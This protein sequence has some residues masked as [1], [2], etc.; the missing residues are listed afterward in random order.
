M[1]KR[2]YVA[3][4]WQ[5]P[6]MQLYLSTHVHACVA[7]GQVVLLDVR[8]DEYMG[9]SGAQAR[10]LVGYVV[11]WPIMDATQAEAPRLRPEGIRRLLVNLSA[12]GIL[13]ENP[14]GERYVLPDLPVVQSSLVRERPGVRPVVRLCDGIRL[15]R[16][17][18]QAASSLRFRSLESILRYVRDRKQA[19]S[20]ARAASGAA[21]LRA[22]D[23]REW[24]KVFIC[25]RP[26]LF[27][28]RKNCLF[29]SLALVEYLARRR[30][31]PT[32]VFGVTVAPFAAHCWLQQGSVV[33]NDAPEHVRRYTP[34]LSV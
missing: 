21:E 3:R 6:T 11:G 15:L 28:A 24:V 18:V 1:R 12:R 27:G 29:D 26:L 7:G 33:Y 8:R 20:N 10:S 13:T 30:A 9:L 31:F 14:E 32:W 19:R 16:A 2:D 17:S 5:R 34:I 25:L 22:E 4:F 23:V